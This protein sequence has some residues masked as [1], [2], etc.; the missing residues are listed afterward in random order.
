MDS[1]KITKVVQFP[2]INIE[3]NTIFIV[4]EINS[5]N[6]KIGVSDKNGQKVRILVTEEQEITSRPKEFLQLT[7]NVM[8][9]LN[10]N[11]G[12]RPHVTV[13]SDGGVEMISQIIH[14]SINQVLIYF[15]EPKK[16]LVIYS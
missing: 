2:T 12:Y 15:D 14:T 3:P 9:T 8:W 10:H 16:G 1:L 13:L 6:F 11:L 7:P 5:D 4:S